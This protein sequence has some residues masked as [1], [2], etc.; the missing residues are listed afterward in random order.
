MVLSDQG[1]GERQLQRLIRGLGDVFVKSDYYLYMTNTNIVTGN[2]RVTWWT[3]LNSDALNLTKAKIYCYVSDTESEPSV[4]LS[5]RLMST[6]SR[7]HWYD[8]ITHTELH[9]GRC[10]RTSSYAQ[11]EDN[12]RNE[13]YDV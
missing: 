12:R 6:I 2:G 10:I 1:Q 13:E 8:S 11:E 4:I 9:E 5:V 7:K 3:S